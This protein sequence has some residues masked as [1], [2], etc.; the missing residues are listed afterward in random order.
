[1]IT[2][3]AGVRVYLACGVT[4]MRRGFNALSVLVQEVLKHDPFSGHLFVFR[5]RRGD[6]AAEPGFCQAK[7]HR[8]KTPEVFGMQ[9]APSVPEAIVAAFGVQKVRD[10]VHVQRA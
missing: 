4:D 3:P 2:V 8:L 5:G 10:L 9:S 6:A 1:M 7:N